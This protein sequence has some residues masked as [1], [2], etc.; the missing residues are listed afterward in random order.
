[1]IPLTNVATPPRPKLDEFTRQ[2]STLNT[3]FGLEIP[4]SVVDWSPH[5]WRNGERESVPWRILYEMR[6]LFFRNQQSAN[7]AIKDFTE[8]VAGQASVRPSNPNG[9]GRSSRAR[10]QENVYPGL[11]SES[12]KES[13]QEYFIQLIRNENYL[14]DP[15][16][17]QRMQNATRYASNK[18][19]SPKRRRVSDETDEDEFHTAPSS[20]TKMNGELAFGAMP[21]P[22]LDFDAP[23]PF[24]PPGNHGQDRQEPTKAL[25]FLEKLKLH[26]GSDVDRSADAITSFT[27]VADSVFSAGGGR[28]ESFDTEITEM[29]TQSTYADSVVESWIAEG[30]TDSVLDLESVLQGI[31]TRISDKLLEKGPFSWSQPFPKTISLL[32]RFEMERIGRAWDVPLESMFRSKEMPAK[33]ADYSEFWKWIEGHSARR[34]KPLP[35]KPSRKAWDAATGD[36]RTDRHSE[37]VAFT[38]EMNWVSFED[39]IFDLKLHPPKTERT[40]RFHRRFGSDRFLTLTIPT[41]AKPPYEIGSPSQPSLLRECIA[42]WLT[43]NEHRC[44]GR[45]W[46]PFFVEEVKN[47]GKKKKE[48]RFRID[49]F[50]VDGIDFVRP[51]FSFSSV[52]AAGQRS[53]S[54]T[55]MTLED[56]LEWH[57]PKQHNANQSNCKLFQRISLGLSKTFTAV[58]V[59]PTQVLH[60]QDI[61]RDGHVFNDG[62]ALMSRSLAKKICESL[63][64]PGNIPSSFQGRIAGAKGL[65][66]VDR[67]QSK[68]SSFSEDGGDDTWIE[69][70]SSQLKIEPHPQL[71]E[72][73][74]DIEKLTFEVVDWSKPLHPV[75][76]NIQLLTIL[77]HGANVKG[78]IAELTRRGL[79]QL[80]KDFE[81]VFEADSSIMCLGLMQKLKPAGE[82]MNKSRQI[83]EW[84]INYGEFVNRLCQAGFKPQ[85]FYPL[86]SR[87]QK[88]LKWTVERRVEELRIEVPLSTYAYCIADPYDVLE[89]HEVHCSFSANWQD[90]DGNFQESELMET[91]VLV[92]RL[93][94]LLPSDIQRR[95]AVYKYELRHFKDVIVFPRKG[96]MPL[97]HMLSGGDY[98]GDKPWV[99]WDPMIVNTF[100][101]SNLPEEL[102]L[103]HDHFGLTK[104]SRPMAEIPST[105]EF[106]RTA[107]EFNLTMSTLGRCTCEH[108]KIAYAKSIDCAD[109]KELACLLSHLVDGRKGGVHLSE[110]V[111]QGYKKQLNPRPLPWPAYKE[112]DDDRRGRPKKSNIV[113]YIKFFVAERHS[114]TILTK[115]EKQFPESEAFKAIDP[116]LVQL[117]HNVHAKRSIS[118]D[119]DLALQDIDSAIQQLSKQWSESKSDADSFSRRA[120]QL[121]EKA[122]G[123]QPPTSGSHPLIHT[124][125]NSPHEWRRLLASFTYQRWPNG[126][127]TWLAFGDTLCD[128]K[129]ETAPSR[130]ITNNALSCLKVNKK[131]VS[132]LTAGELPCAANADGPNEG[133]F[134][135]GED[136]IESFAS[137]ANMGYFDGPEESFLIQ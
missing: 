27:T 56:M 63:G 54:H 129:A 14:L 39:G 119:L 111:W 65:W 85:S 38:G 53:D 2:I 29:E 55:P 67:V 96:N 40:C 90:P 76:L 10:R 84:I 69:I 24:L 117:W 106:M 50:A 1:M 80:A 22:K 36:F 64:I 134:F 6:L 44:L 42:A 13:R 121:A 128:I 74:V 105:D 17:A 82:A 133:D 73:P 137:G 125:Q 20:P 130:S 131:L 72:E 28:M 86:R 93:P 52:A 19:E 122:R 114:K 8:W 108:E 79:E 75:E 89:P 41:L 31:R 97:A 23:R 99:C 91:D 48:S 132:Q 112:T 5:A 103:S 33:L 34:G 66:M 88:L 30:R 110:E 51:L 127:F 59:K 16:S 9:T 115:L 32:H 135:E 94:A 4:E 81:V 71:W 104:H 70:S 100:K 3:E 113:D 43:L 124:W 78:Y 118:S 15:D 26:M 61:K 57:M 98:D 123:L 12:E 126:S 109:A 58:T 107:F 49:F 83:D 92:G 37:V 7:R 120:Q 46:K 62:C 60:Q 116:D 18:R 25:S 77:A 47:K 136:A 21:P 11:P 68:H 45:T 101:N 87:L 35:E 95:K 102:N